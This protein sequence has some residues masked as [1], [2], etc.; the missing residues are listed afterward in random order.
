MK[1]LLS[2]VL[3]LGLGI[4]LVS[5]CQQAQEESAP[6][7]PASVIADSLGEAI[8]ESLDMDNDIGTAGGIGGF[9][10]LAAGIRA[11]AITITRSADGWF[12]GTDSFEAGGTF[13]EREINCKVWDSQG[14]EVTDP[15]DL[16]NLTLSTIS[17]IQ[18]YSIITYTFSGG[19]FNITYGASKSDPLTFT[20]LPSKSIDGPINYTSSYQGD[21]FQITFDYGS[22][23]L[24][25]SGFPSGTVDWAVYVGSS[26]IYAGTIIF[27]GTSLA[28]ITFTTGITGTYL[29]DLVSGVV[30]PASL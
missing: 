25:A 24:S 10:V 18:T 13:Q 9:S 15:A 12:T 17:K 8:I 19:S 23:G 21:E 3:V 22:L 26:Q 27:N 2:T 4:L 5:G 28:T 11:S 20:Y 16:P 14:I 7:I 1:K 6:S 30:T 29:V